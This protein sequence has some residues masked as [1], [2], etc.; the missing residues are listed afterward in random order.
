M[1]RLKGRTR[2]ALQYNTYWYT[3]YK[4]FLSAVFATTNFVGDFYTNFHIYLNYPFKAEI[5][6][7]LKGGTQRAV[8]S[9]DY[10]KIF[11]AVIGRILE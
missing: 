8:Q 11:S 4:Y 6:K 10:K 1:L 7:K 5:K 9:S 3:L 2:R